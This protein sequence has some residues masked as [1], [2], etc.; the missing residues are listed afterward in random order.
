MSMSIGA[1]LLQGPERVLAERVAASQPYT[2]YKNVIKDT[3]IPAQSTP[4]MTYHHQSPAFVRMKQG[5][6]FAVTAAPT[7]LELIDDWIVMSAQHKHGADELLPFLVDNNVPI[8]GSLV[9][10]AYAER[11]P[12]SST[13]EKFRQ[14]FVRIMHQCYAEATSTIV[15]PLICSVVVLLFSM[16]LLGTSSD[17]FSAFIWTVMTIAS[18][19]FTVCIGARKIQLMQL[20]EKCSPPNFSSLIRVMRI[21]AYKY[22]ELTRGRYGVLQQAL[23]SQ[24]VNYL[25]RRY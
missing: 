8:F 25:S 23:A 17:P 22:P 15:V 3:S 20:E 5:G 11:T 16:I 10:A 2:V 12:A 19:T 18:A 14:I 21:W 24:E 7:E 9:K 4:Q 6:G 13:N 1:I